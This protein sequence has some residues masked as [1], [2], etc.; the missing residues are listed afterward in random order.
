MKRKELSGCSG[1]GVMF[2][3][4]APLPPLVL[5]PRNEWMLRPLNEAQIG[6]GIFSR[7]GSLYL[8][9][10]SI[11]DFPNTFFSLEDL[12]NAGLYSVYM[13]AIEKLINRPPSVP[14]DIASTVAKLGQLG[15]QH[16][17]VTSAV[18]ALGRKAFY[19]FHRVLL[20]WVMPPKRCTP[21]R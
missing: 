11:H 5:L 8:Q 14:A 3:R 6:V 12:E 17:G 18:F 15:P 1:S 19:F 7:G 21:E 13:R 2:D 4:T 10:W 16:D 20:S 9:K